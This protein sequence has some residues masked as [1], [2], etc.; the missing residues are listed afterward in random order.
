MHAAFLDYIKRWNLCA[1]TDKI[2]LAVSGGIDSMVMLHLFVKA[3]YELA[4][5]HCNFQLRGTA[6]DEDEE[7]VKKYCQSHQ[8]PFVS[9]RF[10]INN[11][12]S[13]KGI[14][15]QMAARE[16]RYQWFDACRKEGNYACLATA[17][18]RNDAIETVLHNLIHGSDAFGLLGIARRNGYIIRPLLFA[19]RDDI[20]RYAA[21]HGITWR[22]DESNA[23]TEY[24]RNF[25]RHKVVPL[26]EQLNPSLDASLE[27]AIEKNKGLMELAKLGL[28]SLA[29]LHREE[30][31][32]QIEKEAIL[33]RPHP[34]AVLYQIIREYGFTHAQC[35]EV[36]NSIH[37]QPGKQWFSNSHWLLVDRDV[38]LVTKAP[39]TKQRISIDDACQS[40][41]LGVQHLSI[42]TTTQI[43]VIAN[44]ACACID[45]DKVS[46]PLLW[47]PW[48]HGDTFQPLGMIGQKKLSD[49]LIDEKLSR[50]DKQDITVLLSADDIIWVVGHRISDKVKVTSSTRRMLCLQL[51]TN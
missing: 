21:T 9:K 34:P 2:L 44:K 5:A 17:H 45:A 46:F 41:T 26:L 29:G 38:L 20:H 10:D 16:L 27:S 31:K 3:G 28:A 35:K 19:S 4:V 48:Q 18:H 24:Q 42:S 37:G 22:E 15:I 25:I 33:N 39:I 8:I 14:S 1:P 32:L 40:V 6:S 51:T 12:A 7:F 13:E 23:S 43:N 50:V 49:Y 47:R 36:I 30:G 11:Y